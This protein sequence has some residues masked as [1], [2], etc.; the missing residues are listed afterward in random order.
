MQLPVVVKAADV[1]LYLLQNLVG[2]PLNSSLCQLGESV[3]KLVHDCQSYLDQQDRDWL[4]DHPAQTKSS[5]QHQAVIDDA[6]NLAM[7]LKN[8]LVEHSATASR[9]LTLP[10]PDPNT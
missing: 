8:L 2:Q 7:R 5:P 6:Y 9:S 10:H 1:A 4:R 3:E